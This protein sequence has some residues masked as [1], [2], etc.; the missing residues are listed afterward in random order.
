MIK[1]LGAGLVVVEDDANHGPIGVE[2][3]RS[4]ISAIRR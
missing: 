4:E 3:S 1:H 2:Q